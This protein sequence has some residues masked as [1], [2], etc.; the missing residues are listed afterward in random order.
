MRRLHCVLQLI[1]HRLLFRQTLR[2]R[3]QERQEDRNRPICRRTTR[4]RQEG[5]PIPVPLEPALHRAGSRRL[6][7]LPLRNQCQAPDP[8]LPPA[9][10]RRPQGPPKPPLD[11]HRHQRPHRQIPQIRAPHQTPRCRRP[12]PHRNAVGSRRPARRRTEP[13]DTHRRSR[14]REKGPAGPAA[15][16]EDGAAARSGASES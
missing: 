13:Q 5:L 2:L 3:G 15:R 11:R 4:V 16:K 6:Q 12:A 14:A 1:R 9:Q 10:I 8:N 7:G